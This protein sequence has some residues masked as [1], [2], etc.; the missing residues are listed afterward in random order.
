MFINYLRLIWSQLQFHNISNNHD[1]SEGCI[2]AGMARIAAGADL[3]YFGGEAA[4]WNLDPLGSIPE[5]L[6]D[7]NTVRTET[8]RTPHYFV[9]TR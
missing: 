1:S 2:P 8:M 7:A 5:P 4:I 6:D 9:I 3:E